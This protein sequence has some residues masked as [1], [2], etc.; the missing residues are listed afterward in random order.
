[1]LGVTTLR[2][3][4][5]SHIAN[6][7]RLWIDF[8]IDDLTRGKASLT[9]GMNIPPLLVGRQ[10]SKG[11]LTSLTTEGDPG[12]IATQR[13]AIVLGKKVTARRFLLTQA[14]RKLLALTQRLMTSRTARM[15]HE[16]VGRGRSS[17]SGCWKDL[18]ARS[19]TTVRLLKIPVLPLSLS[20]LL[21]LPQSHLAFPR[22]LHSLLS[23]RLLLPP[24]PLDLQAAMPL[25][26]VQLLTF[27]A[28]LPPFLDF[29]FLSRKSQKW[30]YLLTL[31][32][33]PLTFLW[34][35][36]TDV[37]IL[38]CSRPSLRLRPHI[39]LLMAASTSFL[40]RAVCTPYSSKL[41]MGSIMSQR[42]GRTPCTCYDLCASSWQSSCARLLCRFH[43]VSLGP[44][45]K[46]L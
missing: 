8:G 5:P 31:L 41:C 9:T 40:W 23:L 35:H 45:T 38:H 12:P 39:L 11:W 19:T 4:R 34:L 44:V 15:E 21:C 30:S 27:A 42:T 16:A 7:T 26:L 28:D 20:L 22:L 3:A 2:L 33:S 37:S 10:R 14:A 29:P 36:F 18:M 17:K 43:H 32:T 24:I 13:I 46:A 6:V 1:M 25:L